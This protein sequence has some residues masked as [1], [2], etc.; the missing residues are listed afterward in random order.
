MTNIAMENMAI[1]VASFRRNGDFTY[2]YVSLPEGIYD[3]NDLLLKDW[4]GV[5]P[6]G[7]TTETSLWF[8]EK[9]GR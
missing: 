1:Y 2:S 9:Q 7:K 8:D 6:I 4:L 5:A 3:L